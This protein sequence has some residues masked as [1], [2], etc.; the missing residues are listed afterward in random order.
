MKIIDKILCFIGL[1]DRVTYTFGGRVI[2]WHCE[3]C[4]AKGG[5]NL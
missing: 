4:K 2:S 5:L 3:R 1:H